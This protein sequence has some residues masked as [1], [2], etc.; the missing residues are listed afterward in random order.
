VL[1][2]L[3]KRI[4]RYQYRTSRP[5]RLVGCYERIKGLFA[6]YPTYRIGP[7]RRFANRSLAV[8]VPENNAFATMWTLDLLLEAFAHDPS[9][10]HPIDLESAVRACLEF[11][12]ATRE[13][14]DPLFMFWKQQELNGIQAAFPSNL[15]PFF[16]LF[17][18]THRVRR[19][20]RSAFTAIL[21]G[22]PAPQT[23][24][25]SHEPARSSGMISLPADFDDS[26]LNWILGL[27]LKR[28]RESCPDAW[29]TWSAR[30]FD[31]RKLARHAVACAYRPFSSDPAINAIDP[32]SFYVSRTF[33]WD[34]ADRGRGTADYALLTTWAST[35]EESLKGLPRYYKM[36]FNVNNL[37]C[38]VQANFIYA[39]VGSALEGEFPHE[40]AGFEALLVDTAEYLAWSIESGVV[41]TRPDLILLYYPFPAL[42]FFLVSRIIALLTG[43]HAAE[44]GSG[45]P[46]RVRGILLPAVR[47]TITQ[48][49]LASARAT[50][51]HV[52]W[53]IRHP[54]PGRTTGRR[55]R[56]GR[57]E[58]TF[59][60]ATAVNTLFNLWAM[61]RGADMTWS[62]Q[63]P[64]EVLRY[65]MNALR[66]LEVHALSRRRLDHNVFFSASVKSV[67][68]LPFR[69]PANTVRYVDGPVLPIRRSQK[70]PAV[71]RHGIFAMSG[72]PS[73]SEYARALETMD[74]P[75]PASDE[76]KR[77]YD[78]AFP[79]WSAPS[80]T[81][82]MVCLALSRANRL[83]R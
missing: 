75:E 23:E 15:L 33:L 42:V 54:E 20:I 66:W 45:I 47:E 30:D 68:S 16:R 40:V 81:G 61:P 73:T 64:D 79:Y 39:C 67:S 60:T 7:F 43:P 56:T 57:D 22:R 46:A 25:H 77:C 70:Q 51:E 44:S 83:D 82:A 58:R 38:G 31:F 26:A 28:C 13:R 63:T 65:T 5:Y 10:L 37:D 74:H 27:R 9:S 12:D 80:V 18:L 34:I 4:S 41:L 49:L 17:M 19:P 78:L 21:P 24:T 59:I 2:Q 52:W 32:R 48:S 53:D 8:R 6:S 62:D 72:V 3:A 76:V 35:L 50:D 55:T 1:P 36:P 69:Y 14:D 71:E 29:S 11:H